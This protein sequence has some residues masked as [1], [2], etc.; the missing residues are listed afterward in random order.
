[1]VN[2]VDLTVRDDVPGGIDALGCAECDAGIAINLGVEVAENA[3]AIDESV[4]DT[5]K[6]R[7]AYH[8]DDLTAR[9]D[10]LRG[11]VGKAG[12]DPQIAHLAVLPQNRVLRTRAGQ[13]PP[14]DLAVI[15]DGRSLADGPAQ[16]PEIGHYPVL[17][18]EG[19][20]YSGTGDGLA[21]DLPQIVDAVGATTGKARQRTQVREDA[22]LPEV[23]ARKGRGEAGVYHVCGDLAGCVDAR[24]VTLVVARQDAQ[25]R[26]DAV[27]EQE[28]VWGEA[29]V[30]LHNDR[31]GDLSGVVDGI[32]DR[33]IVEKPQAMHHAAT[34]EEDT[35]LVDAICRYA[36]H[37]SQGA[38]AERLA[39]ADAGRSQ[40]PQ[41]DH[42]VALYGSSRSESRQ[43]K[44]KR[45]EQT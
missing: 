14:G 35:G 16:G 43:T 30:A 37:Q 28:A 38:D 8:S 36:G 10:G 11:P 18:Y 45:A 29:V 39:V 27:A 24:G 1:M 4:L 9:I 5:R 41:I 7:R 40:C 32:P 15:V 3:V 23:G 19:V 26:K 31:A 33:D 44:R 25:I 21:D 34:I 2:K 22:V 6:T 20:L 17:P 42:L 13:R 12:Q